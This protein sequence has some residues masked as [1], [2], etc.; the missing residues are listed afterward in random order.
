MLKIYYSS[1]KYISRAS[2]QRAFSISNKNTS[3][4]PRH[5]RVLILGT[6][7][8]GLVASAYIPKISKVKNY[9]IRMLDS[10][11]KTVYTPGLDLVP[12]NLKSLDQIEK[13][14]YSLLNNSINIDFSSVKSIRPEDNTIV[15]NDNKEYTYDYLVLAAGLTPNIEKVEGLEEALEERDEGV[16]ALNSEENIFKYRRLLDSLVAGNVI[17][18]NDAKTKSYESALNQAFL[19]DSFLR[20]ER[21]RGLRNMS[22][23]QYVSNTKSLFS[24]IKY[25]LQI[26][27][28]LKEKNIEHDSFGLKLLSID[29]KNRKAIFQERNTNKQVEKNFDLLFVNPEY[30]LPEPLQGLADASGNLKLNPET[31]VHENYSNIMALGH[32]TRNNNFIPSRRAILE[33]GIILAYNLRMIL[34]ANTKGHKPEKLVKFSG[35]TELPLFVDPGRCLTLGLD[36]KMP[37]VTRRSSAIDYYKEVY[38][39]PEIYF[40][41]LSKG[42]WFN[43]TGFRTPALNTL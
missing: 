16:V 4:D 42:W 20:E 15:T 6:G 10:N 30:Q 2:S 11:F 31:L 24:N 32:C 19:V 36:P 13:P 5:S 22:N 23:L 43:D 26:Q 27:D 1:I 37:D 18:Y 7:F 34:E 8:S 39:F 28:L 3:V 14:V 40:R 12:F 21:G 41:L 25:S 17:F 38:A 29:R 33:Q 9:E 35:Y